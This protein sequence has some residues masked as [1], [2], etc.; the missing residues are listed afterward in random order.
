M[1]GVHDRTA[2][3]SFWIAS[4][5]GGLLLAYPGT[6]IAKTVQTATVA[7]KSTALIPSTNR[8]LGSTQ[9]NLKFDAEPVATYAAPAQFQTTGLAGGDNFS[10]KIGEHLSTDLPPEL[11]ENFDLFIYVSKADQGPF[12]QHMYVFAKGRGDSDAKLILMDDWPVSTGRETVERAKNGER[13][14]TDTP[15]GFYELDPDRFFVQYRSNQW[16]IDMPNAMF[17]DLSKGGYQTGLAIHGVSD[18]D[19]IAALGSRASAGCVQLPLKA[20]QKLFDLVRDNFEGKVPRFA[21][22]EKT[23]TT[24]NKGILARDKDGNLVMVDGYRALVVIENYG[25]G[26]ATSEVS[27]DSRNPPG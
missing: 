25:G 6:G 3:F 12:A 4:I 8:A 10:V 1:P 27:V 19:E 22:D 21:Y 7:L 24:N 11:Y 13:V 20:S 5:L 9:N 18:A 14:S 26:T 2:A 17:L 15:A 16:Q 23:R